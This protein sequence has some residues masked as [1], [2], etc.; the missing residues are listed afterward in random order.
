MKVATSSLDRARPND[1]PRGR[2]IVP[3]EQAYEPGSVTGS[4]SRANE[5]QDLEKRF[6]LIMSSIA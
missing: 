4:G 6:F 1:C 5:S 3:H 2:E